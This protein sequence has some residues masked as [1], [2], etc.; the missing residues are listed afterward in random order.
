MPACALTA[1]ISTMRY[2][3][4]FIPLIAGCTPPAPEPETSPNLPSTVLAGRLEN[5]AIDEASG[6]ARSQRQRGVFWIVNDSGKPRLHAV[7]GNGRKL[8]QVKVDDAKNVDWEDIASFVLNGTPYLLVADIGDNDNKRKDVTIYVVEEP[9][10]DQDE[11]EV[12]WSFDYSYPRGSRDAEALTVD[13]DN[14]RILVLTKRDIPAVLYELPL[15]PTTDDR[16]RA[17]PLGVV[18]SLP[19][20]SRQDVEF[21][22]ATKNW[23]WQP[24]GMD[25]S[26]DGRA[27]VVLTYRGVFYY[28]RKENS[29]WID[30]FQ[31]RPAPISAG[32]FSKAESVAFSPDG[33]SV[34]V[35]F[36]NPNAILLRIDLNEYATPTPAVTVMTFNV[37]NLFD[38]V[39]DPGKDDKAYLPIDA[40]QSEI[41][42]SECNQIEVES[43][44]NECLHLDWSDDTIEHKL[45]V[46]AETI[47]QVG[48][49]RGADII[50]LQEIENI[51]LLERLRN[52]Y[53]LDSEYLPSILIEG[54]D[55]RG[56][57]V[58]FLSRLPVVGDAELHPL[59]LEDFTDRAGDTRGVLE[60][61]F[62]LPDGSLLTGFSA[63][64][65]APFHPSEMRVLAYKHLNAIRSALP[66]ERNV[67]AAGD[68]N[69]SSS[70]DSQR[71]MLERFV[72]P[73]WVVAHD[74]CRDCP[75]TQYYARDESW[76]FLDM[77]LFSPVRGEN[78]T[79]QIRA[80]SVRIGNRNV[81]QVTKDGTPQ[82]Y[83]AEARV[84][85]SDHWPLL[86]TVE[87]AENQ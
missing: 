10:T 78:T 72:R 37:Q 42:I 11:A 21:A 31:M 2:L 50:A 23:Y 52:E 61:T 24:S 60:A 18:R 67:F 7:D 83:N 68:F 20:P 47:K 38:N 14:E 48:N 43:W 35:T 3:L 4:C 8:G 63:H 54:N 85:V 45:G 75:G 29:S 41:H 34:Y 55:N 73:F 57:D 69:T 82:R 6:I 58:A 12:A 30:A 84:G 46:L 87:P 13:I 40:K 36:E 25:I 22:P 81:A 16:Q 1:T 27:A 65:P 28:R 76:S 56:V 9:K 26:A 71:S 39:D 79:W 80:D 5:K 64:F 49:G 32:D 33:R 19:Q 77:I 53:L 66:P 86:A 15:R 44:R 62:E 70:E 59:V 51:A 17:K 74:T